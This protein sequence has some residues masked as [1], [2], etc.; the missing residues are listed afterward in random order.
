[1]IDESASGDAGWFFAGMATVIGT[2]AS[3]VAFLFKLNETKNA[4]AIIDLTKRLDASDRRHDECLKDRA[5]LYKKLNSVME[6]LSDLDI[7]QSEKR[8]QMEEMQQHVSNL[9][10][11]QKTKQDRIT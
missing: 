1:M 4:A 9:E 7:I 2:L 3:V 8:N 11:I 5:D 10:R 6:H